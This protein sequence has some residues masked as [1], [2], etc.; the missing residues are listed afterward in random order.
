MRCQLWAEEFWGVQGSP[1]IQG[2]WQEAMVIDPTS[3]PWASR[4]GAV[5]RLAGA[6]ISL[7]LRIT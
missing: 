4:S 3:S 7:S 5:L 2:S 1:G 6:Q